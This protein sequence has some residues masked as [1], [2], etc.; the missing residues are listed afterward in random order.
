MGLHVLS[1][2]EQCTARCSYN[3]PCTKDLNGRFRIILH[4]VTSIGNGYLPQCPFIAGSQEIL[5]WAKTQQAPQALGANEPA[6]RAITEIRQL[7]KTKPHANGMDLG[8]FDFG[9]SGI[10]SIENQSVRFKGASTSNQDTVFMRPMKNM[11]D[12]VRW[13][14]DNGLHLPKEQRSKQHLTHNTTAGK[15]HVTY[16]PPKMEAGTFVAYKDFPRYDTPPANNNNEI[17]DW[18]AIAKAYNHSGTLG[19]TWARAGMT[20]LAGIT[21]GCGNLQEAWRIALNDVV[22]AHL[23]KA[24]GHWAAMGME[25]IT[26]L[27]I[28]VGAIAGA[29]AL[30]AFLGGLIGTIMA[31]GPGTAEGAAAGVQ[32]AMWFVNI[33]CGGMLLRDLYQLKKKDGDGIAAGCQN[34]FI[35]NVRQGADQIGAAVADIIVQVI[36]IIVATIIAHGASKIR[37][38]LRTRRMEEMLIKEAEAEAAA[39]K[40]STPPVDNRPPSK[41]PWNRVHDE[42]FQGPIREY[43]GKARVAERRGDGL[44]ALENY[45]EAERSFTQYRV[46]RGHAKGVELIVASISDNML[47]HI[48]RLG[49]TDAIMAFFERDLKI[50]LDRAEAEAILKLA[51][52]VPSIS[53]KGHDFGGVGHKGLA[54]INEG[55]KFPKQAAPPQIAE[56]LAAALK[57]LGNEPPEVTDKRISEIVGRKKDGKPL[58]PQFKRWWDQRQYEALD[59][60]V[61]ARYSI[62]G[63]N[64]QAH[65][66]T[67]NPAKLIDTEP[68]T[69]IE[70]GTDIYKA[71]IEVERT[72]GSPI[73]IW[74]DV[75]FR[76]GD[77][78]EIRGAVKLAQGGLRHL[79]QHGGNPQHFTVSSTLCDLK[80]KDIWRYAEK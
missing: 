1:E 66:T 34:A 23:H 59:R 55:M 22:P 38:K 58:Y 63:H 12:H 17:V 76:P 46:M 29:V 75:G 8:I 36:S 41:A 69:L 21:T 78:P 48:R 26:G 20:P 56:E 19:E 33:V 68:G 10:G 35:G 11:A 32:V 45:I 57:N 27:V 3:P 70:M 30:G 43:L 25:L 79:V 42:T 18:A 62:D 13:F 44:A 6:T 73:G 2:C 64:E 74:D 71:K 60:S 15:R 67:E 80:P 77:G 5:H 72:Y 52:K 28:Q 7:L 24:S 50:K 4:F 40:P 14:N 9:K 61:A 49:N 31:P 51:H 39:K 16:R 54:R 47:P 65:H 37:M 53:V